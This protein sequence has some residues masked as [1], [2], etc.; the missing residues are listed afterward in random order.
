MSVKIA[1]TARSYELQFLARA[2]RM[3][4]TI[5]RRLPAHSMIGLLTALAIVHSP[6]LWASDDLRVR[7]TAEGVQPAARALLTYIPHPWLNDSRIIIGIF[8]RFHISIFTCEIIREHTPTI[9]HK[10]SCRS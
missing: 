9:C 4:M 1:S 3:P 5:W 6:S 7:L 10:V 2:L 8:L